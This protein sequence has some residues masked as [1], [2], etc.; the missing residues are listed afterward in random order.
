MFMA[1]VPWLKH[2]FAGG[3]AQPART[4]H[5]RNGHTNGTPLSLPQPTVSLTNDS[6]TER[7]AAWASHAHLSRDAQLREWEGDIDSGHWFFSALMGTCEG[8]RLVVS[9]GSRFPF[10]QESQRCALCVIS[11]IG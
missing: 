6:Y 1:I 2:F 3:L 11:S 9:C 4:G 8:A 7:A 5:D 10:Q